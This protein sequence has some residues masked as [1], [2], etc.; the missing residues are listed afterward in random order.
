MEV[1]PPGHMEEV[2]E[3]VLEKIHTAG[4]LGNTLTWG[5]KKIP[6]PIDEVV[7][8]EEITYNKKRKD[9]MRKTTKKRRLTLDNLI[10]ITQEEKFLSIEHAKTYKFIGVG[11]AITDATLD[12]V[13]QDEK[14][15]VIA[16]KEL[17][18]LCHLEKYYQD[19]TQATIFLKSEL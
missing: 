4:S 14:E 11:M 6:E 1:E 19:S 5:E 12:Q 17:D 7:N 15:L 3:P 9:I 13:K 2:Q 16:L 18:H 8:I 10:L